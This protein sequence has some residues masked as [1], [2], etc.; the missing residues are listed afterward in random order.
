MTQ[1]L[2]TDR[3]RWRDDSTSSRSVKKQK[4][5]ST[6]P[7]PP[8]VISSSSASDVSEPFSPIQLEPFPSEPAPFEMPSTSSY[9]TDIFSSFNCGLCTAETHCVCRQVAFQNAADTPSL[10]FETL[11]KSNDVVSI[12]D[13]LPA[14][15]PAVS[16]RRRSNNT[17]ST[18]WPVSESSS[19]S[20]DPSN[21]EACVNDF[22]GQVSSTQANLHSPN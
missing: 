21:C 13:N 10:R 20:G 22:F 8:S 11:E 5:L 2:E 18:F 14:Y 3:K 6:S 12:L 15:Q 17:R 16:L 19:C 7:S 4:L 1:Q 9:E